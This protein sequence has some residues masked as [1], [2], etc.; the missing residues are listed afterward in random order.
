M[1][2]WGALA[3]MEAREEC[4]DGSGDESVILFAHSF[5]KA[6]QRFGFNLLT[7]CIFSVGLSSTSCLWGKDGCHVT[8]LAVYTEKPVCLLS[9]WISILLLS[10]AETPPTWWHLEE[11]L[12]TRPP[13]PPQWLTAFTKCLYTTAAPLSLLNGLQRPAAH[14]TSYSVDGHVYSLLIT[15]QMHVGPQ[16]LRMSDVPYDRSGQNLISAKWSGLSLAFPLI[17]ISIEP[18][19]PPT[20]KYT[21]ALFFLPGG[22]WLKKQDIN[23]QPA[24]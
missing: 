15:Q 4:R 19:L 24:Q 22:I 7:P 12:L 16:W 21:E 5:T 11:A 2:D 1:T 14:Y 18:H 6:G 20:G 10:W 13:P 9:F 17:S 8:P 23:R 3:L